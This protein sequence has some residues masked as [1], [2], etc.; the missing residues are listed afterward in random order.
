MHKDVLVI[1]IINVDAEVPISA[2]QPILI[3]QA[4]DGVLDDRE[5]MGDL[6]VIQC[7]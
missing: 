3:D 1:H 2:W 7:T 5:D 4:F 6:A